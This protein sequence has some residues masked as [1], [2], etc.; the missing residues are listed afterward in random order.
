VDWLARPLRRWLSRRRAAP[1]RKRPLWLEAL[2]SRAVPSAAGVLP[3]YRLIH[4][5]GTVVPLSS[6]GPSGYT[7][8]QVAQAYGFNQIYFNGIART[9]E[10]QTIAIVDAYNDPTISTDLA[11]FDSQFN[12]PAPPSFVKVGLDVNGNPSTTSFPASDPG[13]AVEIALDVE[14][15]HAMAPGANILLVEAHSSSYTDLDRAVTYAAKQ[16][17]VS[18]VSMSWGGSEFSGE[19]SLDSVFTTPAGHAGVTFVASSGDSGAPPIYPSISPNVLAVG[20]TTLGINSAG[21][22]LSESGWSG[23][24]GGISAYEAQ[25]SYQKGVVTQSTTKR[26]APDVAYDANPSTGFPVVDSYAY[27]TY[28][29]WAQVGGTS[30]G[31]PQWAALIAIADQLRALDGL[32]SLDGPSQTLPMLYQLPSSDFHD[33][34][35]GTSFGSPHYSAGVGYDLVTGRGTPIANLVVNDLLGAPEV[36]VLYGGQQ[37]SSNGSL[38]LSG[39][40]GSTTTYTITVKNVGPA[41]LTLSDPINLPTGFTLVSDFGTTT[42]AEGASTTFTV[43]IANT[44][45]AGTYSGTLSFGTNDPSNPSFNFTLTGTVG[46]SVVVHYPDPGYSET[47]TG[48]QTATGYGYGGWQRAHNAGSGADSAIYQFSGLAT[49]DYTVTATWAP[50]SA[51]ASNEVYHIYDGSTLVAN[52]TVNFTIGP[53]GSTTIN[54]S[55][56]QTLATVTI[57][58]GTLKV[59]IDDSGNGQVA[60]DAVAVLGGVAAPPPV[61]IL[62]YWTTGYS[63]TGTGW[64]TATGYGYGGGQRAHDAGSGADSATYQTSGLATGDYT[65]LATWVPGSAEASNE[66]YH[67]YDGTTLLTD[68]TVNYTIGPVGTTLNG[69]VFQTLASVHIT[70]GTLRVVIDDS[71]NGQVAAD[72]V[73]VLSGIVPPPVQILDYWTTGYSETGTG[74]QTATGYGYGS[75]QRAHDAGSGAD[76]ATY[77]VSG[78]ATGNYIVAATW[79]PGSAEASNE[80]YHIY[81]GTTLVANVT[82]DYTVSPSGTTI[83]GSVFQ[84]LAT[85]TITSGTLKVVIDDSGNGQVAADAIAVITLS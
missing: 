54:G 62:D 7:P 42:L 84:T 15:A 8:G 29:P 3:F 60:A 37:V 2:E 81:D 27:G 85:V 52:V 30:A 45:A 78:L 72:A 76:S 5:P 77:Q 82:V 10:G 73:A 9:G 83:N 38:T 19:K 79:V 58:S 65:V 20:G 59:V 44:S 64:Q 32:S 61:Q 50:G 34:T 55:V 22:Y 51:E 25:P 69:S 31:A 57:T 41:A 66:V 23:S 12:L 43:Q 1:V 18:V 16:S 11:T 75:G 53:V 49:G 33:I 17:G 47:G 71:G 35:S 21:T 4:D 67:I 46:N 63:E 40:V 74:W 80:V 13:W 48:W 6:P 24:G 26:T 14:W 70:S 28:A 56:F 68:V 36:Q 39:L